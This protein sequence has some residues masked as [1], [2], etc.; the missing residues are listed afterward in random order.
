MVEVRIIKE[1][2]KVIS[3]IKKLK[4]SIQKLVSLIK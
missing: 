2:I 4:L 3:I 1:K